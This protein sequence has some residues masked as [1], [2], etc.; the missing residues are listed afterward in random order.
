MPCKLA[1]CPVPLL[2]LQACTPCDPGMQC[3][4]V[5]NNRVADLCIPG[6]FSDVW[7]A[8]QCQACTGLTAA[9]TS[10][11]VRCQECAAG[12]TPTNDKRSCQLCPAGQFSNVTGE[13]CR[14]CPRGTFREANSGDGTECIPCSPGSF[15]ANEGS[16]SCT[17]CALGRFATDEGSTSCSNW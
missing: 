3:G 12:T 1:C 2:P 7:G 4:T 14:N 13:A 10:G 15:A 17:D 11:A 9:I 8:T 5:S 6:T 16:G